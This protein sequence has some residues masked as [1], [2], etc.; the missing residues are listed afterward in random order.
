[1]S[2]SD[3]GVVALFSGFILAGCGIIFLWKEGRGIFCLWRSMGAR[4]KQ[5]KLRKFENVSTQESQA[6]EVVLE[7]CS[8][9]QREKLF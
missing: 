9:Y 5:F 8:R 3:L 6:L 2:L 7:T 1:M 4:K